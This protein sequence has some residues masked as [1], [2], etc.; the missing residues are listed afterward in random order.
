MPVRAKVCDAKAELPELGS[1]S[2]WEVEAMADGSM[3][4]EEAVRLVV[5]DR[6]SICGTGLLEQLW[7]EAG[8]RFNKDLGNVRHAHPAGEQRE[9]EALEVRVAG[10][11][12]GSVHGSR[13]GVPFPTTAKWVLV[14]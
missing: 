6:L 13:P 12:K 4:L 2:G 1:K 8:D 11:P 14:G 9:L 7:E 10:G 3:C 5:E